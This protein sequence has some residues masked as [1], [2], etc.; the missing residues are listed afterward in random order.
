MTTRQSHTVWLG[1]LFICL[2]M[3][4]GWF[5]CWNHFSCSIWRQHLLDWLF[6]KHFCCLANF[7]IVSMYPV[8]L[9]ISWLHLNEFWNT[10]NYPMKQTGRNRTEV[11]LTPNS[12]RK[13]KT[14]NSIEK[15][16]RKILKELLN[17]RIWSM[18]LSKLGTSL[19]KTLLTPTQTTYQ[20]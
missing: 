8:V 13:S 2:V 12:N 7:N 18:K 16:Q 6:Q 4:F 17:Q 14:G 10:P 5:G 3:F 20:S 15:K 19:L 11:N 1:R 9:K